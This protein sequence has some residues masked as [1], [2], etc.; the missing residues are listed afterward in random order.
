M[1]RSAAL[2]R[3]QR[4][5]ALIPA[6]PPRAS[7][8]VSDHALTRLVT[9]VNPASA[10]MHREPESLEGAVE[11]FLTRRARGEDVD[12]R[13]FVASHAGLGPELA[14]AI[15][16]L[17]ALERV[18][19]GADDD[20]VPERVGPYRILREIGRGGMG[21]VFEA[22]EDRLGR[23]V[24]LKVLP[25]EL[26]TSQRARARFRREAE[27]AAKLDHSGI[28]TV[29]GAGVEEARPWIAMRYVQGQTL[30]QAIADARERQEDC[31]AICGAA[32]RDAEVAVAVCMAKVAR[33]LQAAH[34]QGVVHRDV[35]PSNIIVSPDGS[36]VLLDFGL[37]LPEES[38][39]HSLTRTGDTAGTPAYIAP[40]QLSGE[41]TRPDAQSDV[42]AAGVTLYECLALRRP[43]EGPTPVALYRSIAV[44]SATSV[45]VL[46]RRVS[47]DLAVI[48][49]T[50][51]E[52]DRS[53]RYATAAAM[54]QDLE[55]CAAGRPIAAR[56][57]PLTG[58]LLR[59][60]RRE[61]R[62]AALVTMLLVAV[63]G[64][65]LFGGTWWASRD[66]VL[67]AE[68]VSRDRERDEA[69]A[70][71]FVSLQAE[72][73][74]D[75]FFV[76]ALELDPGNLEAVA[77]R[78]LLQASRRGHEAAALASLAHAPT[79]SGFEALRN[80]C[81]GEQVTQDEG[82]A[83]LA[84][85]TSLDLFLVG[86]CLS[87]QADRGP[88]SRRRPD[89]R[90]ALRMLE[91]AVVRSPYAR[92][93]LHSARASAASDAGDESV[94]R[95][96]VD[97]LLVLWPDSARPVFAAGMALY[98]FD[99]EAAA[100]ILE[101]AT[102]LMPHDA[103]PFQVLGN[104]H[105]NL[106][107]SETAELWLWRALDRKR[108]AETYNSLG[109]S[110]ISRGCSDEARAA[111]MRGLALDPWHQSSW[112][113]MGQSYYLTSDFPM[114][115]FCF[116]RC[117]ERDPRDAQAHGML[118]I[119]LQEMVEP[120]LARAHLE[121]SIELDPA[122]PRYWVR[123]VNF[124]LLQGEHAAAEVALWSALE[125]APAEQELLDLQAQVEQAR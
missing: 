94:T 40:E 118:G 102:R 42:Y 107:D 14:S 108:H 21:I 59:W 114:A 124:E 89:Q 111:W 31:V 34:E 100:P 101:R 41:R 36:P 109:I 125:I 70:A 43:F 83:F 22:V 27:L 46:N 54:A 93:L 17:V 122:N 13:A 87:R 62:Q 106:G 90:R 25:A 2:D 79:T 39:G 60:A 35:K 91:E 85:A 56:P 11:E 112:V 123:L 75:P 24:A 65:A 96:S 10:R 58:K 28:A 49:A 1:R 44:G 81:R 64:L 18:T 104:L 38:D 113:N 72:E 105:Q 117:L 50:A 9:A 33:A 80:F 30:S 16:A 73:D 115:R 66:E 98:H 78:A 63:V 19:G 119:T 86:T 99:P 97:A 116:E 52:R 74:A 7:M 67:A 15:D 23:R 37:A 53:R 20:E 55:A 68:K 4:A 82:R 84:E 61:P 29:F 32:A 12:P 5:V 47:R 71:G 121:R 95:S 92:P 45:R 3:P 69:L 77:G 120:R 57:V 6:F 8:P 88:Y 103:G 26:L 51:M 110:L 48:V 76:R